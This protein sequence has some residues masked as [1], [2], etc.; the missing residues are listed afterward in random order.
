MGDADK[1]IE[2]QPDWSK[3]YQRKAMALQATGKLD[4]AIEQYKTGVE[5]DPNNAQCKQFLEAA[6]EQQAMAMMQGMGGMGGLGGMMGGMGGGM[7]GMGG[8]P[9]GGMG[10]GMGGGDGPFSKAKLD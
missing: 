4:E 2:L 1:C 9:G 8:M 5:K 7:P 3:G 6:E 10:G